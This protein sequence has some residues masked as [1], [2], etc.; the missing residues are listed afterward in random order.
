MNIKVG[1]LIFR[2][3]DDYPIID[4]I[5]YEGRCFIPYISGG[6]DE[7]ENKLLAIVNVKSSNPD[8][9]YLDEEGIFIK[10]KK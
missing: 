8:W 1:E 2:S 6:W 4:F 9:I 10:Q 5:D 3:D 7:E